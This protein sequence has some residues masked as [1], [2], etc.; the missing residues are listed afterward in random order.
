MSAAEPPPPP[1]PERLTLSAL[2]GAVQDCRA[3]ELWADAT[4]AVM[5]HWEQAPRRGGARLML[6]GEQPGDREDVEGLPF[7]GPAGRVLDRGLE[8]AGISRQDAYVTNVVK[9]FRYKAR[10]K[11]R[12]HQTPERVHV[13]A[14][15]PWLDAELRLVKPQALVCLGATAAQALLGS[16]VRVGRDRGRPMESDL[17]ELVT[18][19]THPSAILRQRD[20]DEREAAMDE[21]VADLRIVAGWLQARSG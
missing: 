9:H 4:Q 14:C 18:L 5:G 21:F 13:A 3:C 20:D 8:R 17:A 12:I 7:V 2:A 1:I 15:R 11:R 10:G 16:S 19:T 6:V